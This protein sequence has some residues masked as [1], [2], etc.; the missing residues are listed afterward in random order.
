MKF[1]IIEPDDACVTTLLKERVARIGEETGSAPPVAADGLLYAERRLYPRTPCFLLVD[2]ATHDYA[3]RAFIRNIS[4]DGAFI[5][6]HRPV[7][8]GP[9]VSLVISFFE[10]RRPVKLTGMICRIGDQGIGVRFNPV[11][12]SLMKKFPL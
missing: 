10:G 9:E 1:W 8:G 6:S 2:F 7:P 12:E 3:Y 11:A 5:E 4:A